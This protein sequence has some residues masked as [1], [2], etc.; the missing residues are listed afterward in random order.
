MELKKLIARAVVAT[1]L[2]LATFVVSAATTSQRVVTISTYTENSV[3]KQAVVAWLHQHAEHVNGKL[4][5]ELDRVGDVTVT[6]NRETA[7][8]HAD[9]QSP[10]DGPPVPLPPDGHPGDTISVS[11][12]SRGVSQVW[13]YTWVSNAASGT[14]GLNSYKYTQMACGFG[15]GGA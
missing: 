5:G 1:Q 9:A 3:E 14:W 15:S 13:S 6:Y 8:G 2:L 11:S 7:A 10:G 12:C 4:I